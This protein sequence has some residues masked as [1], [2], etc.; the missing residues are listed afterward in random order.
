MQGPP[1]GH[2]QG[3]RIDGSIIP[4]QAGSL[5]VE[6][7][8]EPLARQ[9]PPPPVL[10]FICCMRAELSPRHAA[11]V[12]DPQSYEEYNTHRREIKTCLEW[13]RQQSSITWESPAANVDPPCY[14]QLVEEHNY[15]GY[16]ISHRVRFFYPRPEEQAGTV[17]DGWN[18]LVACGTMETTQRQYLEDYVNHGKH[19]MLLY[20]CPVHTRLRYKLFY[21]RLR[22]ETDPLIDADGNPMEQN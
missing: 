10:P 14:I 20:Q 5:S 4:D 2:L 19:T 11:L 16:F 3:S 13:L 17:T 1:T 8:E 6:A 22:E 15:D 9:P 12:D 21:H 18:E 7:V